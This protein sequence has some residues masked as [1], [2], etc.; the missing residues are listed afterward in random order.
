[1]KETIK[2]RWNE[3]EEEILKRL[4]LE[5]ELSVSKIA[6]KMGRSLCS[7]ANKACKMGLRRTEEQ[8]RAIHARTAIENGHNR[9]RKTRDIEDIMQSELLKDFP[10]PSLEDIIGN[11][12]DGVPTD[13]LEKALRS[14]GYRV[15]TD[16]VAYKGCFPCVKF[17]KKITINGYSTGK[18]Y[19]F[20]KRGI[21]ETI[22]KVVI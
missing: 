2:P 10:K 13:V 7:V 21:V 16:I 12:L 14:Y 11:N 17:G 18:V 1:M 22:R 8:L 15:I 20:A 3:E 19:M 4:Y 6:K 5:S 9:K